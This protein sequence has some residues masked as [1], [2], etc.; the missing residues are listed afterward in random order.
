[1]MTLA[2]AAAYFDRTPVLNP[3]NDSLL[4][5]GQTDPFDDSKRDAGA[6]YRRILSVAP[7]TSVPG[8][9]KILG[10]VWLVGNKE[11]DGLEVAFRDKYVLQQAGV[12]ANISRLAG[13]LAGTVA[14]SAWS[15]IE[16]LKDAREL[17]VSSDV[18]TLNTI[19]FPDGTDLREHDI[20]WYS[21]RALMVQSPR[22]QPSDYVMA[23]AFELE[24]AAPAAATITTRTYDPA[25]GS[26]TTSG[27]ASVQALRVRWQS[28]YR[29]GSQAD[30]R[31]KS[32]DDTLVLPAATALTTADLITLAGL[33]W[34][35]LSVE[36][37]SGALVAH[38]RAA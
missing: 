23:T 38:V 12:K 20:V 30:A 18:A 17:E 15:S 21:G 10:Q 13:F 19:I 7:G 24:Q 28:L 33:T 34:R 27:T 37:I 36:T 32:G 3:D 26:Y 25:A 8:A 31:Y 4:F 16:W 6:A 14:S 35:V 29:Y 2:E 11:T 1:M 5:Y 9:V 22:H